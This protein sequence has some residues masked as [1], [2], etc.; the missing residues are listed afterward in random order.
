MSVTKR[1]RNQGKKKV[2]Y[3][4]A[5]VYVGGQRLAYQSFDTA[6]AAYYWHDAEKKRLQAGVSSFTV[7][8]VVEKYE[9]MHLPTVAPRS[10]V[11]FERKLRFIKEAPLAK[12]EIGHVD[13]TAIDTWLDWLLDHEA[14]QCKWRRSF[15]NEVI[16]LC[17]V[18]NWWHDYGDPKFASPVVPRHHKRASFKYVAPRRPDYFIPA[19]DLRQW[20]G[21]LGGMEEQVYYRLAAFQCLTG[22]RIGEA[23][24]LCWDSVDLDRR[25]ARIHRTASEDP[26]SK[27]TTIRPQVKTTA[28]NRVVRLPEDLISI[29]RL[30]KRG[31]KHTM[32]DGTGV[33]PVFTLADGALPKYTLVKHYYTSRFEKLGLPWRATHI[34][35]HTFGTLGLVSN[36]G[37][38]GAVQAALGHT[39]PAMTMKYAKVV[40]LMADGTG[41]K[42]ASMIQIHG[43]EHGDQNAKPKFACIPSS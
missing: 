21:L 9:K 18:F 11:G 32:D 43:D 24:G 23:M 14:A 25:I 16:Q 34:T 40:A 36:N 29:L 7:A 10:K 37:N 27:G 2:P 42:V 5:E 12:V 19:D 4:Q 6:S 30:C 8:E 13:A 22:V 39:S 41:D 26:E 1:Y 15:K 31:T 20:L 35:R 28:S 17:M 3:F 38:A 33:E